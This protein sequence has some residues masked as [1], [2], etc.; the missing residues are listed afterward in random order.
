[1]DET[2]SVRENDVS[3]EAFCHAEALELM[4]GDEEHLVDLIGILM[5]QI[6]EGV[7]CLRQAVDAHDAAGVNAQAHKVKGSV[8]SL[9]G[10]VVTR[11]AQSLE[12]MGG[13]GDL[14][15]AAAE[16]AELEKEVVRLQQAYT[17]F[18]ATVEA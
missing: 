4:G 7:E 8:S 9:G 13:Q 12:T 11:L 2:T 14:S 17:E 18:L 1:M 15:N 5:A 6:P 10:K 16:F 3:E